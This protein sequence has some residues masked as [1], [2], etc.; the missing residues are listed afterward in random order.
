MTEILE[1]LPKL[2]SGELERLRQRIEDLEGQRGLDSLRQ[3][4]LEDLR[5]PEFLA[6][7]TEA[8]KEAERGVGGIDREEML[9]R[10]KAAGRN[11]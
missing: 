10:L 11:F 9:A 8:N 6:A 1:E 2:S 3:K 5:D 4:V 7:I